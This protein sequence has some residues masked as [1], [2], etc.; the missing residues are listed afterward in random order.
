M[1]EKIKITFFE[2]KFSKIDFAFA[3]LAGIV[4][5]LFSYI[6]LGFY[7][8]GLSV[9][10][11]WGGDGIGTYS[12]IK[13]VIDN[14]WFWFNP[15]LGAPFGSDAFDFAATFLMQFE[16]FI[17]KILSFFTDDYLIIFN[18]QF[19]FTVGFCAFNAF[20]VL[21]ILKL[22]RFFAALGSVIFSLTP[23]IFLRGLEHYC[24]AACYFVPFSILICVWAS[25]NDE[26]YLNFRNIKSFVKNKK[27]LFTIL[28]TFLIANNG[29]G[30]YQFF[31]C[32][33][34]CVVAL[35][36]II[37]K[38][39]LSEIIKP[40][41]SIFLIV[42]LMLMALLPIFI[43][44][45]FNDT[46]QIVRRN[47]WEG[48]FYALKII[49]LFLPYKP[50]FSFIEKICTEYRSSVPIQNEGSS[51]LGLFGIFGFLVSLGFM[52]VKTTP[53]EN[54]TIRLFSKLNI[55]SVLF[56]TFGGFI[57]LFNLLTG[58]RMLRAYNR[59]SIFI[60]FLSIGTLCVFVQNLLES[61]FFKKHKNFKVCFT[62]I[63]IIFSLICI[64]ELKPSRTQNINAHNYYKSIFDNDDRFV[65]NIESQLE[66]NDAVLCLPYHKYPE[67][68]PVNKMGDYELL[69]GFLHSSKLRWSYGIMKGR[70]GDKWNEKVSSLSMDD[71][72]NVI[73]PSGFR[74][75]YICANAYNNE[76][77]SVLRDSI[78]A[79]IQESPIVSENGVWY[80]YN[81][82]AY[83]KNHPE[84]LSAEPFDFE[85]PNL[86]V[87]DTIFCNGSSPNYPAFISSGLWGNENTHNWSS[88]EIKMSFKLSE[89]KEGEK[90]K[91]I[92]ALMTVFNSQQRAII[93]LNGNEIE[94]KIVHDGE[95]FEFDFICPK[96]GKC[97]FTILLPDATSPKKLGM[98]E[99]WRDLALAIR[100]ISFEKVKLKFL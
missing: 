22:N 32:F 30:Y 18:I 19:L 82:N 93:Y 3:L 33:M 88:D 44:N 35:D 71:M 40:F 16:F 51:Y 27:N 69:T 77:L 99:D 38:D 92:F 59:V 28:F 14:G 36:K 34:L 96:D 76:E 95:N 26:T 2:T 66:D 46:N 31:T 12:N 13:S 29:I 49:Q 42:F 47:I 86:S 43:H 68:G 24:L 41:V 73:I 85:Y 20:L 53:K 72:I 55:M 5:Y 80:F 23:Y 70:K 74:G 17:D 8:T 58:F 4:M 39:K 62:S 37:R 90:V 7:S 1:Y 10:W 83:I 45:L 52:F 89:F 65:K 56:F 15:K 97:N 63:F 48:E 84:L 94:Q 87:N 91:M 79:V 78:E 25:E 81:L 67:A 50:F 57:I 9:P 75:I 100:N 61:D 60:S 98:S 54:T 64:Y 21:R 11:G 6:F